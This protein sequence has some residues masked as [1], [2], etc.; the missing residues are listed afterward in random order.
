MSEVVDPIV[1]V[2]MTFDPELQVNVHE[3][4][5]VLRGEVATLTAEQ[6]DDAKECIADMLEQFI[7]ARLRVGELRADL[8]KAYEDGA[9]Y[10]EQAADY[11]TRLIDAGG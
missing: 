8:A 7:E 5:R 6:W 11:M 2:S 4:I 10:Q 1:W 9:Q 3:M